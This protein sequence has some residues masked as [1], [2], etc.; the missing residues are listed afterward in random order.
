M[1]AD[2]G[3]FLSREFTLCKLFEIHL[4]AYILDVY[5]QSAGPGHDY[6]AVAGMTGIECEIIFCAQYDRLAEFPF[7]NREVAD[8]DLQAIGDNDPP[9]RPAD[10]V[11]ASMPGKSE[12]L[13]PLELVTG[14]DRFRSDQ[15]LV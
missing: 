10:N 6:A 11:S 1:L 9:H 15:H 13:R 12:I 8:R 2:L 4:P 7:G 3:K 5:A 14:D